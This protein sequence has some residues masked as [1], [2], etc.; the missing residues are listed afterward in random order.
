MGNNANK[1]KKIISCFLIFTF[2][3]GL[4]HEVNVKAQNEEVII[5][6]PKNVTV[7]RHT[8]TSLKI[9]WLPDKN[10]DGYIIYR[11]NRK[12]KKYIKVKKITDGN[13]ASWI[14]KRLETN[15]VYKYRVKSYKNVNGH[16]VYS[17]MSRWV[18]AK[19]YK[20][21][22][23][24]INAR[25]PKVGSRQVNIG[26]CSRKKMKSR[27]LPSK[28]GKNENKQAF[29]QT[30]RWYSSDK[31]IASVDKNGK[32]KATAKAGRCYVYAVAHNGKRTKITVN[33]KNYA[34]VKYF[35]NFPEDD[36]IYILLTDYKEAIQEI[37]EYYSIHRLKGNRIIK[38]I[39]ND[40]AEVEVEPANTQYNELY[41]TIN[42][43][44]VHFPYYIDIKVYCDS[45]EFIVRMED[46]DKSLPGEV[47]FYFDNDCSGW[48]EIRIASHWNAVRFRPD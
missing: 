22:D 38:F 41:Q 6:A 17:K 25:A 11:Y 12:K 13:T 39:L 1:V 44:L 28:Y 26:L 47:T 37:A 7:I 16:K 15:R 23:K 18:K 21:Y 20:K 46:T 42:N 48:P 9:K 3:F 36:D 45:V 27:V 8:N 29:D 24:K 33:V 5:K 35:E 43:L 34:K 19:T 32:I 31:S 30:L 10:A 14:D 4:F 2:V 40:E